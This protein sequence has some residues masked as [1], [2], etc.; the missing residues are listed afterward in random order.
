M[1]VTV[2][3]ASPAGANSAT[4]VIADAFLKGAAQAGAQTQ[5]IYLKDYQIAHCQGCFSCW[6]Q[7]PGQCCLTDDMADLMAQYQQSDLVCFAT[8]VYTW[9]MTAM[10]KNFVDRLCPL[11]SPTLIETQGN[12]DLADGQARKQTFAVLSNCGFPGE[13]NF[14]V[15]RASVACC[16][17]T[18]E[19]YR[20]CGKLLKSKSPAV[21]ETVGHWLQSV[22]QAGREM[23]LSGTACAETQTALRAPLMPTAAYVQYLGMA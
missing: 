16:N 15:L 21:L 9:N 19:I 22:T 11:K 17:P 5:S 3:N 18:L 23:V 4:Q 14:D 7:S 20:N 2:F 1:R 13:N 6:F 12:F 10:L 8:P